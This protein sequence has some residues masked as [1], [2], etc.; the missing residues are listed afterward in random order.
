MTP[1]IKIW[2]L[3]APAAPTS[4]VAD[5]APVGTVEPQDAAA[6]EDQPQQ[7]EAVDEVRPQ[8]EQ[9]SDAALQ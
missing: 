8:D 3:R 4:N 7:A 2:E 5:A 6:T 9:M 1:T